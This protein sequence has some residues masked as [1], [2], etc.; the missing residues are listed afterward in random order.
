MINDTYDSLLSRATFLKGIYESKKDSHKK[1][2]ET[3]K[4]LKKESDLLGKSEKVLKHL[5]DK[6]AENDLKKM[7]AL[8]T[9]GLNTVYPDKNL[10]FK[11]EIQ[12]RGKKIWV[13]MQTIYN[14]NAI[15]P[16]S[17]SSVHVIES[18]LLRLLC[19]IKLKRA[20]FLYMDESF[21]AL[22]HRYID[23]LSGLINELSGKLGMD[24]LLVTHNQMFSE[25]AP[26]SY[27]ISQKNNGIKIE[28]VK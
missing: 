23:N 27:K 7:D 12:E 14:G 21:G 13:N 15:D 2:L 11:S 16:K 28:K 24:I 3:V 17:R 6:F 4:G 26:S 22:H 19:I 25:S 8:V 20:F 18:F 5:M 10:K 1:A 9:Y